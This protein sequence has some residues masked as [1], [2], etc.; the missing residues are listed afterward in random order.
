[1]NHF[2]WRLV[3][4]DP[5]GE[6]RV[7]ANDDQIVLFCILPNC[8]IGHVVTQIVNVEVVFTMLKCEAIGQICVDQKSSHQATFSK[9]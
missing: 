9:S 4:H 1:M 2:G 6:I 7:L 3:Q 5:I 8:G